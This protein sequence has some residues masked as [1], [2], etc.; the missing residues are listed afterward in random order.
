MQLDYRFDSGADDPW[1]LFGV[2]D[3]C[4][5]SKIEYGVVHAGYAYRHIVKSPRGPRRRFWAFT[6]HLSLA[7]GWAKN[8][9]AAFG[10][11]ERSPAI[12]GR[13]GFDIDLHFGRWFMGWSIRYEG[14]T[15]TQGPVG[16]SHFFSW[17]A[18]PIFQMGVDLGRTPP[19]TGRPDGY[20]R[21][22]RLQ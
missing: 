1:C 7:A 3:P 14:L 4:P 15:Q 11:P 9:P 18:I 19:G 22:R 17:N 5:S 20:P 2:P 6:P 13:L 12:G 21:E 8:D 16:L 10:I